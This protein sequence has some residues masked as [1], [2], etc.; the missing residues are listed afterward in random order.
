MTTTTATPQSTDVLLRSLRLPSFVAQHD[1]LAR[2]AERESWSFNQYL[3]YLCE[4]EIA[5]RDRRRTE[6][7]LKQSGLPRDKNLDT[8]DLD[9]F[10]PSVVTQIRPSDLRDRCHVP[11][12]WRLNSMQV[13]DL[14]Q[15]QIRRFAFDSVADGA[16]GV[17]CTIARTMTGQDDAAKVHTF[18]EA[19]K[20]VEKLLADGCPRQELRQHL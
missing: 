8:L 2:Q 1:E 20:Q 12:L 4:V 13:R 16:S 3:H 14:S 10:D 6:R 19:A 17:F 5:D 9:S 15:A 18:I 7:L 11:F